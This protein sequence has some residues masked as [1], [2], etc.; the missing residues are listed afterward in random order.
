MQLGLLFRSI[1]SICPDVASCLALES[2][3]SPRSAVASLSAVRPVPSSVTT[4][5]SA[6]TLYDTSRNV[7]SPPLTT[8][9]TEGKPSDST[10]A[11]RANQGDSSPHLEPGTST[12]CVWCGS[13]GAASEQGGGT[14]GRITVPTAATPSKG[15][16]QRIAVRA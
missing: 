1:L 6:C 14:S 9:V 15:N 13:R 4:G 5:R 16:V 7:I 12:K 10:L 3:A 8:T 11:M 2:V